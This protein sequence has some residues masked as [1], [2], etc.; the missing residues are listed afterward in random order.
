[1]PKTPT[2]VPVVEKTRTFIGIVAA[3]NVRMY[4]LEKTYGVQTEVL[5]QEADD[6]QSA[7]T[8]VAADL[9]KLTT[10]LFVFLLASTDE[11]AMRSVR[12]SLVKCIFEC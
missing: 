4:K 9:K 3:L 12:K 7:A 2:G 10:A 5:V 6:K 8:V 11:V 1:M